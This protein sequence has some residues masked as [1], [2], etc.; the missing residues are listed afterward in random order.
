MSGLSIVHGCA[1]IQLTQDR[2]TLIDAADYPL[3]RQKNWRVAMCGDRS[4]AVGTL[5]SDGKASSLYLYRAIAE[6]AEGEPSPGIDVDHQN[7]DS[8]DNR[9]DNLRPATKSRNRRN[10]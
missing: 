1:T 7:R 5:W 10:A 3:V 8:S 4:Y 9:C 2:N 6:M